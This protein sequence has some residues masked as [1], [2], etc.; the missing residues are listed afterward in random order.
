MHAFDRLPLSFPLWEKIQP[1]LPSFVMHVFHAPCSTDNMV[2]QLA[3][4]GQNVGGA[5]TIIHSVL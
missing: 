4:S 5:F 2:D 1:R 3:E